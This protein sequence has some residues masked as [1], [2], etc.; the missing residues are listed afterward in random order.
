MKQFFSINICLA[1]AVI[2]ENTAG[3][4]TLRRIKNVCAYLSIGCSCPAFKKL[5]AFERE[6]SRCLEDYIRISRKRREIDGAMSKPPRQN[7][8][9]Y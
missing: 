5:G 2:V 3:V 6:N 8:T 9:V 4:E 1:K 7:P